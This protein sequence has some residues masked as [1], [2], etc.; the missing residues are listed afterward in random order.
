[1]SA[2]VL[3]EI[4]SGDRGAVEEC[5]DQF[6]GLV[7]SMAKRFCRNDADAEDAVQEIFLEVW[8]KAGRY[9]PKV[10]SPVTFVSMIARRRLID[11]MRKSNGSAAS[12]P[13]GTALEEA[14]AMPVT[15]TVEL[16]DEAAK[17]FQ[18]MEHLS[19]QQRVILA[20]SIHHGV[21]HAGIS[22]RLKLPLGTVKSFA[23]RALLQLR[24]CMLRHVDL[25]AKG[26][27]S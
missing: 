19:E 21:S 6:G 10:A 17:A 11:R 1:L 2:S 23:R 26:G 18:C 7:W 14:V 4:A 3:E 9:D 20:L 5:L 13:V 24:E 15:D 12:P 25:T 16:A 22:D 8:E 27:V